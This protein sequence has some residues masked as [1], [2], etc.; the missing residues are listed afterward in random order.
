MTR[1]NILFNRHYLILIIYCSILFGYSLIGGRPLTMHEA[2]L[3]Q[4]TNEMVTNNSWI[5]PYSGDRP[6]VERPPLP[7]WIMATITAPFGTIDTTWKARITPA[8]MGLLAVL[9]ITNIA[10][11]LFGS[12]TG[13]LT[14][15]IQA[16]SFEFFSYSWLAED[17]IFLCTLIYFII[18]LFV[19]LEFSPKYKDHL[20]ESINPVGMRP[21]ILLLFFICIGLTNMTKGLVFGTVM[22]SIPIAGFLLWNHD[23]KKILRYVWIWGWL[24]LLI[25]GGA[26]AFYV[27]YTIDGAHDVWASDLFGRLSKGYLQQPWY[28]YIKEMPAITSPWTIFCLIGIIVCI[29]PVFTERY[30]AI[31]FTF[32]WAILPLIIFSFSQSKHH[33]YMLHITGA[34]AIYAALSM[35]WVWEWILCIPQKIRNPLVGLILSAILTIPLWIIYKQLHSTLLWTGI[36]ITAI[37]LCSTL[38]FYGFSRRQGVISFAAFISAILVI[39]MYGYSFVAAYTD[40][41]VEDTKFLQA[42]KDNVPKGAVLLHN[43]NHRGGMDFFRVMF[44]I[45]SE[46]TLIHN[47]TYLLQSKYIGKTVY[48]ID[49]SS[50][51]DKLRQYGTIIKISQSIHSRREDEHAGKLTLY[52]LKIN[53]N[54]TPKKYKKVD[55]MQAMG[56]R[57]GP[58]LD[59]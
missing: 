49:R 48:L 12:A 42:V 50:Q 37:I 23:L 38:L 47:E 39:A 20:N 43:A 32:C 33:H 22:C 52:K 7:H 6:W 44:Y 10:A 1:S 14:G 8:L 26:W 16:T 31:R 2:R 15:F 46:A 53:P 17:D 55:A 59:K 21:A 57:A 30:S 9:L 24:I 58:Y 29:K 19:K 3:P 18:Y 27:G 40:Q 4:T 54:L 28:Y 5:V 11:R 13:I 34:W 56:R 36:L 35:R 41:T 25:V 45:P 51:E